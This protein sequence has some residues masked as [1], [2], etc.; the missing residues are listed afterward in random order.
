MNTETS[1]LIESKNTHSVECDSSD[2]PS[3]PPIALVTGASSGIG[4]AYARKLAK[5][6][7]SLVL[8]AR[9]EERL[10]ALAKEC[11]K[12][13]RVQSEVIRADLS[14]EEGIASVERR[15]LEKGDIDF[16]VHSA[17]YDEFGLFM[18]I[19]IQKTLGLI[20]CL[21]LASVR[22]SRVA[23]PGMLERRHGAVVN[24][25]SIGAF[26]PKSHD[27]TYLSSKAYLNM[28]TRVLAI[29]LVGKGVQV[30]ALCPGFTLSEFH[31]DP[32]YAQFRIK[33][34]VPSWL[35][36]TSEKVVDESLKGLS[37]GQIVCIPGLGN[38]LI[39]FLA[40]TGLN[41]LIF[42]ILRSIFSKKST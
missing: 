33:E 39:V 5:L 12:D 35:W 38:R 34:R 20:N 40:R 4:Q 19:P 10:L 25:S 17:G 31:D 41:D 2:L 28:F 30:Q 1:Q 14:T 3:S 26:I 11:Q 7:Y 21:L 24:V 9:R 36:M 15:I 6:G 18:D 13:Y 27:S 8:V 23:L 29:E 42:R 22:I 32:Q 16:F 37:K